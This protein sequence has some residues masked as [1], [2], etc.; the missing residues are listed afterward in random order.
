MQKLRGGKIV[1]LPT[2]LFVN[3]LKVQKI[4]LQ[5]CFRGHFYLKIFQKL[6]K[7]ENILGEFYSVPNSLVKVYI[8]S[9]T[10]GNVILPQKI[11]LEKD[12]QITSK[13]LL[14]A[15]VSEMSENKPFDEHS[16]IAFKQREDFSINK[17]INDM[18]N[19]VKTELWKLDL[20][21]ENERFFSRLKKNLKI[22]KTSKVLIS[23][24]N[25]IDQII[26][27][28]ST[29]SHY[30][31]ICHDDNGHSG[32]DRIHYL[33]RHC[34]WPGKFAD[35]KNYASSCL[36]CLKRKGSYI[37]KSNIPLKNLNHGSKPFECITV[38]FVHMPQSKS[39]KKYILT[40]MCNFSRWL[41]CHPTYRDRGQ[42]AVSGLKNFI[43]EYG[44]P[45]II[46]SDRGVHFINDIFSN[47]CEEFK[48]HHNIH[49]AYRPQSSGQLERV[50]RTIKNTLWVMCHNLQS[51]WEEILPYARRAHNI[52]FNKAIKCSPHFCIFGKEPN[53]TGLF[54]NIEP[55]VDLKNYGLNTASYLRQA[56]AA[57]KLCQLEADEKV[58]E[59]S[60]IF[61][62]A[63]DIS[64][65]DSV[66]IKR[67]Q[68]VIAKNTH[69]N[70]IGPFEVL[71]INDTLVFIKKSE[72]QT[73]FIHRNQIVKKIDRFDSLKPVISL[74]TGNAG[75]V[76]SGGA[77]E[78]AEK[79]RE[80]PA[81][82]ETKRPTRLRSAPKR[83]GF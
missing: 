42:D 47:F 30:L 63:V 3:I 64:P 4:I 59:K 81:E 27:P 23:S 53:V 71:D 57:V 40:I 41:Y 75:A 39:G 52:N 14:A 62:K 20:K 56:H 77:M 76:E 66:F 15:T 35:I 74:P 25:N 73:D 51:D 26:L 2:I 9:W 44:I 16:E 61:H 5:I 60:Q 70:W 8:P 22:Q 38:D 78:N 43:L 31:K 49:A 10:L 37:Q 24:F 69:L 68:S 12:C 21:N 82:K 50:H 19:E 32:V 48:I 1:Y 55:K 33:L 65:G 72:N 7:A 29:I 18:E 36:T 46:G 67:E 79:N 28:R 17:I 54:L 58:V 13:S 6:K 80:D 34:D 83:Y 11:I 45:K